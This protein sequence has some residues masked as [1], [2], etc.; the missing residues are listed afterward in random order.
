MILSGGEEGEGERKRVHTCK[1]SG[2][3]YYKD[4]NPTGSQPYPYDLIEP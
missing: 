4:T 3:S 2:I 1:D